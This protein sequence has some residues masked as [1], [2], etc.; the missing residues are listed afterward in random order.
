MHDTG[1][2]ILSVKYI[3]IGNLVASIFVLAQR[4]TYTSVGLNNFTIANHDL[5]KRGVDTYEIYVV[6]AFVLK[7]VQRLLFMTP[8]PT[9]P[10]SAW[11]PSMT[12]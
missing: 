12:T 10:I 9:Q 2:Y 7:V 3:G 11:L 6:V 1:R 5:G 4:A 8:S